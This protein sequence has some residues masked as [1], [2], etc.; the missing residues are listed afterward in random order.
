MIAQPT[1]HSITHAVFVG[2]KQHPAYS[3]YQVAGQDAG[4]VRTGHTVKRYQA[5]KEN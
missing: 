2:L 5:F 1:T 3:N 4:V